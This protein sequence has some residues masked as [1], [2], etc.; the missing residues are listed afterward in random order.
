M[1]DSTVQANRAYDGGGVS[2]NYGVTATNSL[3]TQNTGG[4]FGSFRVGGLSVTGSMSAC[5]MSTLTTTA[6][7]AA[8][9]LITL[10][11]LT[12]TALLTLMTAWATLRDA[13][14]RAPGSAAG[15][16][17]PQLGDL[18]HV[19]ATGGQRRGGRNRA[20]QARD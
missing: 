1:T 12:L 11:L 19:P 9:W 14:R 3:V 6:P 10:Q 4:T 13:L 20:A 17:L 2:A 16:Q 15:R 7:T 18:R 5:T 8:A